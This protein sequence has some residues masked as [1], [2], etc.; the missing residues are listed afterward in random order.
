MLFLEKV[1][2]WATPADEGRMKPASRLRLA[3]RLGV[4]MCW[5]P[6]RLRRRSLPA[7]LDGLSPARLRPG[8]MSPAE[9][10]EVVRTAL[11]V[12]HFRLFRPPIF[13]RACLRQ[14]LALY[15]V[16]ARAGQPVAIRFGVYGE[17]DELRAHSWVTLRGA[18]VA[19]RRRPDGLRVVYSHPATSLSPQDER[20]GES[21]AA[22]YDRQIGWSMES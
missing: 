4:W 16:L 11:A 2:P 9:I 13:P 19:E 6:V 1:A 20:V 18:P 15:H 21:A 14:A 10:D 8:S 3:A 5:L 7:L 17:G 22:S 12:C